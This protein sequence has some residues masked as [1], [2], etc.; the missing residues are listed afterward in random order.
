MRGGGVWEVE[1]HRQGSH[2]RWSFR[3]RR[4][5]KDEQQDSCEAGKDRPGGEREP[6]PESLIEIPHQETDGQGGDPGAVK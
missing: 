6:R 4:A 2:A 5:Q 3:G 1:A